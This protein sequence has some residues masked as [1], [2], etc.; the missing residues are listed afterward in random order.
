MA[1]SSDEVLLIKYEDHCVMR[2]RIIQRRY[3]ASVFL[4]LAAWSLIFFFLLP[5]FPPRNADALFYM[6]AVVWLLFI[7]WSSFLS[8]TVRRY[9]KIARCSQGVLCTHCGYSLLGSPPTGRCPECGAQYDTTESAP[10]IR[11][12]YRLK[13][14]TDQQT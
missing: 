8:L 13:D 12:L 2:W 7:A 10:L 5:L 14:T 1:D 3:F 9:R 6:T 4:T 11:R